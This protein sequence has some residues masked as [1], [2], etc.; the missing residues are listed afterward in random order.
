MVLLVVGSPIFLLHCVSRTFAGNRGPICNAVEISP[1]HPAHILGADI[2]INT[3][4]HIAGLMHWHGSGVSTAHVASPCGFWVD[5][6]LGSCVPPP[7]YQIASNKSGKAARPKSPHLQGV[8]Q[9]S[10]LEP[11]TT[12]TGCISYCKHHQIS[13]YAF[14]HPFTDSFAHS[15]APGI[16][17]THNAHRT[18]NS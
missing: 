1:K 15:I 7:D 12:Y 11:L 4:L 17:S 13:T 14:T 6:L 10:Q 9:G 16:Y 3:G 18:I 8:K 5:T 2:A